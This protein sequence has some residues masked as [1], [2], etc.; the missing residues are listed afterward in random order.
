MGLASF[1][2]MRR[3]QLEKE[4]LAKEEMVSNP[5]D[6]LNSMKVSGLKEIAKEKGI[7]G[8]ANMKK[9]ELIQSL[10]ELEGE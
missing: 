3:E 4:A 8:Y 2:R 6:K 1:N 5:E 10:L 7:E 9:E